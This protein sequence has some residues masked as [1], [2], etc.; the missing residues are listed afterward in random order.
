MGPT[1]PRRE[2]STGGIRKKNKKTRATHAD[3]STRESRARIEQSESA[4]HLQFSFRPSAHPLSHHTHAHILFSPLF[5]LSSACSLPIAVKTA[6]TGRPGETKRPGKPTKK[7]H[8]DSTAAD[9]P[10]R[11]P[12][13]INTTTNALSRR[14]RE[15]GGGRGG[16]RR[17][18]GAQA[19]LRTEACRRCCEERH[20]SP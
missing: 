3:K 1:P 6:R 10:R 5:L 17:R 2:N 12:E 11:P 4:V 16:G 9:K 20:T 8:R 18:T 19:C 7:A 15:R 13:T 14:E